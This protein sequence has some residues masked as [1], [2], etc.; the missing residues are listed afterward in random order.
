MVETMGALAPVLPIA[1]PQPLLEVRGLSVLSDRRPL[2]RDI[3]LRIEERQVFGIIGPSG[4]GKSTL[5]RCLNRLIE[6]TPQLRISGDVLFGGHSIYRT[7]KPVDRI[8]VEIGMLFQQPVVFPKSIYQNVLFGLRHLDI[9]PRRE[10]PDT[11]ERVLRQVALWREVADR[12]H[13]PATSLSIGQ[14]QRLCLARLLAV[15]PRVI[16]MDEPTSALD[17]ASTEAIEE[18]IRTLKQEHTIVLVS[19]NMGQVR[20]LTDFLACICTR[21][22]AGEVVESACCDAVFESSQCHE[23]VQF[24]NNFK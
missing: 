12:L 5:L 1:A 10:W 11:V 8:R 9:V 13:E 21:D 16:L 3:S 20:R 15:R 22:G 24:L 7:T 14:Q 4:A 6:L 18:L 2:L 23:V 17:P 19:H